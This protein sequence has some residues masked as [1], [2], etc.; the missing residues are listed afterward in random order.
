MLILRKMI[1]LLGIGKPRITDADYGS[2]NCGLRMVKCGLRTVKFGF[3]RIKAKQVSN[4]KT[5]TEHLQKF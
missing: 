3:E 4:V 5:K 2:V 1:I